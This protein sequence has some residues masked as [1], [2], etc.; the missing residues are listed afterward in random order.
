MKRVLAIAAVAAFAISAPA[1]AALA[2]G[3]K[4]PEIMATAYL[5]GAPSHWMLSD[6]LKKGPVVLYFFPGA[7]TPG[8]NVE[9]EQ[10]A[11]NMDKFKAAGATVIG[12][13]GYYG[14]ADRKSAD[15][16]GLEQ[17][18]KDFS[19]EKCNGKFPVAAVTPEV[20]K[21]YDVIL[22]DAISNRTS[23]VVAPNGTI[24][25]AYTE[26]APEGHITKSLEALGA[27]KAGVKP[28]AVNGDGR[29]A[30]AAPKAKMLC[31]DAP[32]AGLLC[33]GKP[34]K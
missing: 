22:R 1:W 28:A 12:V 17:A 18:V 19:Q 21:A 26:M 34:K 29:A 3:A 31:D 16:G 25:M 23:F 2:P 8:C 24:T 13:T 9:A 10:F 14:K 20:V 33:N 5:N 4:A 27:L 15:Q 30:T 6:A 32:K 11:A 7:F